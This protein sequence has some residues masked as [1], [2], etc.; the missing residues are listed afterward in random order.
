[1]HWGFLVTTASTDLGRFQKRIATAIVLHSI[2]LATNPNGALLLTWL[3][4]ASNLP[5]RYSLLAPRF[6]P[7]LSH[8]ATHK[9]A[10]LT[11]LRSESISSRF[12]APACY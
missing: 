10:S 6:A 5:G 12:P 4:D 1:M 3:V 8:L 11:I 9:L 2:P 7:Y